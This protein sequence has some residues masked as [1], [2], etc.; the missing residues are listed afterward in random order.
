MKFSNPAFDIT[1][2]KLITGYITPYG[3]LEQSQ[4]EKTLMN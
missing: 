2:S 1:P 4:L 3:I